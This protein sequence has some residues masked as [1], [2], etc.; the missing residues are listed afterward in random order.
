MGQ[1]R[2]DGGGAVGLKPGI[3]CGVNRRQMEEKCLPQQAWILT[4]PHPPP[5]S[6]L[7][8]PGLYR[9]PRTNFLEHIG[10]LHMRARACTHTHLRIIHI[11]MVLTM[12]QDVF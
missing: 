7:P 12:Y 5:P 4:P 6:P 3:G 10:G 11:Y 9:K 8:R 1:D 2:R